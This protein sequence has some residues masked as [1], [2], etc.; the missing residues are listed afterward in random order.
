MSFRPRAVE[1]EQQ[2]A[3]LRWRRLQNERSIKNYLE[4]TKVMKQKDTI[5]GLSVDQSA[6]KIDWL[7]SVV[8]DELARPLVLN[9][10]EL[11]QVEYDDNRMKNRLVRVSGVYICTICTVS[12]E[13]LYCSSLLFTIST[14]FKQCSI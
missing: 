8:R 1:I 11:H 13:S 14:A 2:L 7:D 5:L 9:D 12:I 10:T 3:Q 4:T 6:E